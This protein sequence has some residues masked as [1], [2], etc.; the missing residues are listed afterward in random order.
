APLSGGAPTE[1]PR[2]V[3]DSQNTDIGRPGHRGSLFDRGGVAKD[4]VATGGKAD[5]T[6]SAQ[7]V[8]DRRYLNSAWNLWMLHA[9]V[10]GERV[11]AQHRGRLVC[12]R[13][14]EGDAG[15][16]GEG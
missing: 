1:Q 11:A 3:A 14:D 4:R 9:H 8:T 13:A 2:L 10:G 7:F 15:V 5:I 12:E 16:F 6:T